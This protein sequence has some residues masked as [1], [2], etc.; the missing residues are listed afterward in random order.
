MSYKEKCV[1]TLAETATF[2]KISVSVVLWYRKNRRPQKR[3]KWRKN[4][5]N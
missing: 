1:I 2:Y 3:R 4:G 5:E